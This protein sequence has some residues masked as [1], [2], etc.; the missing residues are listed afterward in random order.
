METSRN[1]CPASLPER[2]CLQ[3]QFTWRFWELLYQ[4]G[5]PPLQAS[6]YLSRAGNESNSGYYKSLLQE[7]WKEQKKRISLFW[8]PSSYDMKGR[9]RWWPC[10]QQQRGPMRRE[11]RAQ[12]PRMQGEG[13]GERSLASFWS[14]SSLKLNPDAAPGLWHPIS[15]P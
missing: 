5:N 7:F 6:M 11:L 1:V 8:V 4:S 12:I 2:C 15:S 3:S 14:P 10:R 9:N 13:R